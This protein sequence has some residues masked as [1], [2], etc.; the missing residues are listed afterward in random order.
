MDRSKWT[1][2]LVFGA[3]HAL[4]CTLLFALGW[5][6]EYIEAEIK[7]LHAGLAQ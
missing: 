4:V 1:R 3:L 2:T 5:A 7:K 6:K